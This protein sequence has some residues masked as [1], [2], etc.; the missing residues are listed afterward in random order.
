MQYE[1]I[2]FEAK[3][4][5]AYLTV[6]R[7]AVLNALR[8][9]TKL[10]LEDA[11]DKIAA[12][13]DILGAIITGTGRSFISGNDISEIR[14]D[15]KGEETVAM[16]T[17]AHRLFDKFEAAGKPIIAAVNGFAMG[18][19][20]ELALAC[21][22]RIASSKAVFAL[23]EV[24]LGVAPCYGGTQRLPRLI[25]TGMAKE[26]L[27]TGRKVK[28]D[29][30]KAIGLVNKVVEPEELMNEAERMMRS[31]LSNAPI[32][33]RT[34]K[35]LVNKGM[36]MSLADGLVYEAELNGKLAETQDAKE[37]VRSFFEKRAPVF[38]NR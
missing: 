4:R 37:G 24:H 32:A 38:K 8:M 30:A 21:D 15:V 16:S 22:I 18:G 14:V 29:E 2:L 31:I 35:E 34:C 23:P 27:F 12:D 9:K 20:T 28:A 36:T 25:G 17:Q 19:G 13:S 1:D 11:I 26:M 5:V 7:P 6:N 10:E 33:V 3:D